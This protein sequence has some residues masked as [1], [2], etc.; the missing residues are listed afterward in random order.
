M[1]TPALKLSGIDMHYGY[2]RALA[3]IDFHVDPGEVVGLLGD[4]GAGKST[5]LKVMSGAHRPSGGTIAVHGKEVE[6]HSPSDSSA[7]GIQMV[8]QDLALVDAQDIST[9]L[10]IGREIR[11]KGPLGWLGFVDR[12]AMRKRSEA[13]L[14]RLGVRTAPMTRPVEML[15]GGQRQVVALARSAIRVTGEADGVLL[16]DEPTAALGYEQTRQVEALIRRL[17]GQGVAIVLVT[18]NLPL[19]YE[20]A[21]RVVV[22]NRGSK[23][24]DV[25]MAGTEPD[26][27]V[28]WITGARPSQFA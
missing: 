16:L 3:G 23:V 4:N 10:N 7:A 19:C 5:L 12:R 13:E 11:Y 1:T 6:F 18:H 25:P 15:S 20:V 24:A 2:V 26:H 21:D 22:L 27:V 9:N 28:G 17:A 14:D 8:Y